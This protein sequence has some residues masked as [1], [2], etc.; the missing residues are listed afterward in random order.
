MIGHENTEE[1]LRESLRMYEDLVSNIPSGVYRFRMK[2]AGGWAFDFVSSRFCELTGLNRED[3]LNDCETVFRLIHPDD[4]TEFIR[5]NESVAKTLAPF[6]WEGR[7]TLHGET[8]WCHVESKATLMDNTDIVWSGYFSDIT[9]RKKTETSLIERERAWSTLIENLPGFAYRCAN[10][11]DWSM[12]YISQGCLNVTGYAPADFI[13]NRNLVYNDLVHPDYRQPLWEKCQELLIKQG[14]FEEEYPIIAKGGET[15]WVWE[16]GQ[17]IFSDEGRLL[18][19]EGFITD[20]TERKRIEDALRESERFL[21]QSEKIART[22]G[23]KA[24][25]FTNSLRWTQGVYDIIEAPKEYQPGLNEGLEYYTPPYIPMLKEALA[26]TMELGEPFKL[27]TEI[28]TTSGKHL[29]A[30][31]RGLMRVEEGEEPQ[32]IGTLQDITERKIAE[33]AV[34]ESETFV[35][36]ILENI[37]DMIFV[38]SA[39]DLRFVRFNKA[40][41][42]LLGYS[43][44]ALLGK[45]D[46]DFFPVDQADFFVA[47]DREVLRNGKLLE[48]PEEAID[49]RSKGKRTLHTKKIPILDASGAP[50]YLL[51]I[52]E[53]I[54]NRRESEEMNLRL[55][56]IVNSSDDAIIGKTLDGIITSWNK[57]AEKIYGFKAHEVV[58]KSISLLAPD[59]RHEELRRLLE[60]IKLGESVKRLETIR[61]KKDGTEIPISLTVSPVIDKE[62]RLIG[63]ATIARDVS[64]RLRGERCRE[65]LQ[66]QLFQAQKMEAIGTL[67]GGFAHDFNN[68]LQVIAGYVELILCNEELPENLKH[69]MDAIGQAVHASAE[70]IRE[71]LVFSRKTIVK[72]EQLNLNSLVTQLRSMLVPVMPKMIGI[73]LVLAEDLWPINAAPNQIDQILMNLSVNARDAMPDGGKLTIQTQNTILDEEYCRYHPNTKPGRYVLLSVMDTGSG[74]D[75]ATV[76]RIFEPFFTTKDKDKGTGLGLAV[77]Y[78]IVELHKGII[79]CDSSPSEGTTFKIY[80]PA[81]EE[82]TEEQHS[83]KTEPPKGQGET[84]LLVDDEPHLLDLVSRQLVGANYRVI[85]ASNGKEALNLYKQQREQISLVILDLFMPEMDGRRCL[86]ALRDIDPNIRVLIATGH[87]KLGMTGELEQAGAKGFIHKPFETGLFLEEIRKIIDEE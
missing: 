74:M 82:V 72:F 53:D 11:R 58:G 47:K 54:T 29:W 27:E 30:E 62:G 75:E 59:D 39:G 24:N 57:G 3:V 43:R 81:I 66:A 71:M 83:K 40:G 69:D 13:E 21:S 19:L 49:S 42:D 68:K 73:N 18:F 56:A 60:Q 7:I 22:G 61:R 6:M 8:R 2:A 52:S 36:Q 48:I 50:L 86:E 78:G 63:V 17:G 25:P 44:E 16:R 55:A 20:I 9:D 26:K 28:M 34:H 1:S 10:D 64:D 45:N 14:V 79:I 76:N 31:V 77:V 33:N 65:D 87:A 85:K 37:P 4:L 23:W 15:R 80:L 84:I 32:V 46:Y 5:L 38:K 41:E 12:E 67:A 35:Q 51:G 70:L